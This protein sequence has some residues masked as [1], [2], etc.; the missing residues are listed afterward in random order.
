MRVYE[1][2]RCKNNGGLFL[3]LA[4][5]KCCN[6]FTADLYVRLVVDEIPSSWMCNIDRVK[7]TSLEQG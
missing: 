5:A 2:H 7:E 4:K 3:K 6:L 1:R